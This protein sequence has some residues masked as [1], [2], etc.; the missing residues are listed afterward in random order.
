M[1]KREASAVLYLVSLGY[2]VQR[3]GVES[4]SP[5][6]K[7]S[8]TPPA[9]K[10][11]LAD[12]LPAIADDPKAPHGRDGDG[13]PLAPHGWLADGSRPRKTPAGRPA[14]AKPAA[15]PTAPAT[16]RPAPTPPLTF[17]LDLSDF[18]AG[19]DSRPPVAAPAQSASD[20]LDSLEMDLGPLG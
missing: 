7:A 9:P 15:A 8:P 1:N 6:V 5:E 2:M 3:S 13:N 14:V 11:T 16:V 19:P 20:V 12:R 18:G 17:S 10:S 4:V